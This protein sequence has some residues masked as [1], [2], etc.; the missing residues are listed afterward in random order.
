[1]TLEDLRGQIDALDEK[2]LE[3]LNAR[4]QCAMSIAEIKRT[5]NQHYYVPEREKLIYD[6]VR[7]LNPGP[8]PDPAV[9][10]I[11][12]EIISAVRAL[13]KPVDVAFLG[14]RDTFSHIAALKVF[15]SHGNYHPVATVDD[16]FTEV[17][18]K[19]VDYGLVPVET[20]MGGGLS[21]TLDRFISSDLKI[22]NE[23]MLHIQQNLLSNSPLENITKVYSKAQ[24]FAQC[25]N[26]LKA[27]LPNAEQVETTST[28][29]AARVAATEPGTAAIASSLA[30][31]TYNIALLIKGIEDSSN[32]FTRF[33]VIGRHMAKPT[34]KDKTA[35][36]C[37][38]MDHPGAL[39]ELLTPLAD[40]GVNLTRIESR[41]SRRRAWEYVFFID[42][43]GHADEPGLKGALEH[44]GKK[45]KELKVLGSFPQGEL[46]E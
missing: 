31:E 36:L 33:F 30:A 40:V 34:G 4:A 3:C 7:Q 19:R 29:E 26:W 8:L 18:R 2:I 16:V 13:E 22:M 46:E 37:A 9:K 24:P 38:I 23:V 32:N 5:E 17:E 21:D 28:A 45:C 41:P 44:V 15:G 27:N 12:R 6:K 42:M 10:A 39:Y 1:M 20:S 35:I 14:P 11:Y 43:L 25:R